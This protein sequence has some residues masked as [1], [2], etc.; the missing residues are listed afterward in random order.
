MTSPDHRPTNDDIISYIRQHPDAS[1]RREI[2]KHFGLKGQ[3]R[4]W[5]RA[6]LKAMADDGLIEQQAKRVSEPSA[7]PG[8]ML[9]E[10]LP[11]AETAT[12]AEEEW[13]DASAIF[14][15]KNNRMLGTVREGDRVLAQIRLDGETLTAKPFKRLPKPKTKTIVGRYSRGTLESSNRRDHNA[16]HVSVEDIGAFNLSDGDLVQAE[17]IDDQA[18]GLTPVRVLRVIATAKEAQAV[19][20]FSLISAAEQNLRLEFPTA[21]IEEAERLAPPLKPDAP[22]CAQYRW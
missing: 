20:S 10:I 13:R 18:F 7:F 14:D 16:F 3:D 22:I 1:G 6:K 5:L 8:V 19:S 2:A 21:V 4:S 17:T 12:P 9:L 11:G 15:L